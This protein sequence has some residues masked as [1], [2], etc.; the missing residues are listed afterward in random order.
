[1]RGARLLLV[2]LALVTLVGGALRAQAAAAP[3]RY[4]SVDERA[5]ARLARNLVRHH[6]YGDATMADPVRWAPGA[7]L[8]FAVAHRLRPRYDR[9][10][11]WD[12]PAAYPWQ[13]AVGTAAIPATYVLAALVAG[14]IAGLAAA[15]AVAL[16]PPLIDASGDLLSEPLGALLLVVALIAVV[17]ALRRPT[18]ARAAVAG[19]LLGAAVLTRADMIAVPF[20]LAVVLGA[21]AWR[22]GGRGRGLAVGAAALAGTM[23]LLGP[24]SAY[25]SSQAGRFVPVSSGG[26][27]NLFVGTY[28][29]G[30]GT[31]FGLKRALREEVLLV[32]PSE[33]GRS[34]ANISQRK[35]IDT[36]VALRPERD[37]EDALRGA[38]AENLR[39]YALGDPIAYTGMLVRKAQRLWLGYTVGTHGNQRTWI[40][41]VH[42][43]LVALAAAGL[44]A[45]LLLRRSP[46]LL[47]VAV[48]L[49]WTT[50][51]NLVL[52]SE[53]RH[54]L[55][56]MPLVAVAGF[57]GLA[58]ALGAQPGLRATIGAMRSGRTLAS[59]S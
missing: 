14:P 37:R 19:A 8:M 39:E 35:Y 45:G 53:A 29:P 56:V 42:L 38:A 17:L 55:P 12:V 10:E 48:P 54:N 21:A 41:A 11:R 43:L 24:W 20:L 13:A 40:L 57:A 49:A 9:D 4:Q 5:Y 30:D 27:S 46:A 44:L 15:T 32:H 51:V 7:P 31:I 2:A 25:A 22:R 26:A 33:R 50:A 28:L 34:F 47:A 3:S 58:L 36:V 18:L 16:Y 59:R 6:R 1:M 52:V 23:A